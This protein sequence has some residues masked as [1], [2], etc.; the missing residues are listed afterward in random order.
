MGFNPVGRSHRFYSGGERK[1]SPRIRTNA[2]DGRGLLNSVVSA[3]ECDSS[4]A[5]L[6]V[7][8]PE[9][10]VPFGGLEMEQNGRVVEH[11]DPKLGRFPRGGE[12]LGTKSA[13]VRESW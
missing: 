10:R 5:S 13:H 4:R 3:S 1:K 12:V 11:L 9:S 8:G 2:L 6:T 7:L